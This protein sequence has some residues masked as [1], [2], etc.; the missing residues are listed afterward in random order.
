MTPREKA[1]EDAVQQ[2]IAD[3]S[4]GTYCHGDYAFGELNEHERIILHIAFVSAFHSGANWQHEYG[5]PP[6]PFDNPALSNQERQ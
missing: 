5:D 2:F 3:V 4:D 1:A 6:E